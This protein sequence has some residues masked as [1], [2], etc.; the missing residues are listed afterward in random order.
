MVVRM[1]IYEPEGKDHVSSDAVFYNLVKPVHERHGAKFLGRYRD[2][3]GR[4]VILWRYDSEE[5]LEWIQ[6]DVERDPET[7]LNRRER[8][9]SGL[10]G[11]AYEE[12]ILHSTDTVG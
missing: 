1:R 11:C 5:A 12:F 6:A 7:I 4:V 9:T 2:D 10:H 8:M 3:R